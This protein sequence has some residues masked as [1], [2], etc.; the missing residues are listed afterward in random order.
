M[1]SAFVFCIGGTGL[2]VMKSVVML[3][4]A[5]MKAE[6]YNIVPILIDPHEQLEEKKNL[7]LLINDYK[8]VFNKLIGREISDASN[9][10]QEGFFATRIK[11]HSEF[12]GQQSTKSTPLTQNQTLRDYLKVGNIPANDINQYLVQSLLSEAN[13]NNSLTVGFKGNPNIGT[14]V[15]GD[16]IQGQDWWDAFQRHFKQGDRVFIISSIFG[17]TGASGFP[18]IMNMIKN[19]KGNDLIPNALI[20][21]V[22]VFPYFMLDDPS[23]TS[24]DIDSANFITKTKAA[25]TYYEDYVNPDYLYYIG[26]QQ[27]RSY[28]NNEAEQKNDA[29]FV[30]LVAATALFDFLN[31]RTKQPNS[32][33]L[34]R[35][36]ENVTEVLDLSSLGRGYNEEVRVVANMKLLS[37]LMEVLEK[38]KYFPLAKTHHL[39]SNFYGSSDYKALKKFVGKFD[40]WYK[41]ISNNER[42]FSPLKLPQSTNEDL[43]NF[44]KHETLAASKDDSY[45]LDMI[46]ISKKDKSTH[47]NLLRFFLEYA[48]QAI[49]IQTNKLK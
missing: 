6:D 21:A 39:G 27:K 17:G 24:S 26:D 23:K 9:P 15:L 19:Y 42:G 38:E 49:D 47:H 16:M 36:I 33:Y 32:Q 31:N 13:L 40:V 37:L 20:G 28:E 12:D 44:I 14:M 8:D 11:R 30:E 35:A 18:L 25:L 22:S 3:M 1:K 7:D 5:G 29:H 46:K 41:E 48:Y 45:L 2:R 34:S 10:F 4:A 43:T